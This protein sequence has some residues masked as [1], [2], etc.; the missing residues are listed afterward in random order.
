M[1]D[2]KRIMA[3]NKTS[4]ISM[5]YPIVVQMPIMTGYYFAL[6]EICAHHL[7]SMVVDSARFGFDLTQT[8]PYHLASFAC[9]GSFM[10][11]VRV[12]YVAHV[13]AA[14]CVAKPLLCQNAIPCLLL[15]NGYAAAFDD[16]GYQIPLLVEHGHQ[17]THA[18]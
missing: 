5:F 17:I 13:L 3:D 16:H 12:N 1:E 11:A 15:C 14:Y 10:L 6:S 18:R 2:I 8:D 9:T 7:P 4:Y